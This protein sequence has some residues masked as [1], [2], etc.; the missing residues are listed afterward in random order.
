MPPAAADQFFTSRASS[1]M[2]SNNN[3]EN[4]T[5][6]SK[7]TTLRNLINYNNNN[8]NCM[9]KG[10]S[11]SLKSSKFNCGSCF[12]YQ[13][14]QDQT[15]QPIKEGEGGNEGLLKNHFDLVNGDHT[16]MNAVASDGEHQ[17]PLNGPYHS[18]TVKSN[19]HR[20]PCTNVVNGLSHSYCKF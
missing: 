6:E 9:Q 14:G 16:S 19:T 2:H 1:L 8:N 13:R 20:T 7:P 18:V 11:S 17:T 5:N 10:S 3:N 4:N 15:H 12:R